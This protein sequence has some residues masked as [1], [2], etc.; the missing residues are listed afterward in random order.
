MLTDFSDRLMALR[1]ESLMHLHRVGDVR[2]WLSIARSL[3]G[4]YAA[5]FGEVVQMQ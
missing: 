2:E 1:F 5:E 4:K 3:V